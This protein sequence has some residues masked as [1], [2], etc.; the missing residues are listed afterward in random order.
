[1]VTVRAGS[2]VSTMSKCSVSSKLDLASRAICLLIE[3]LDTHLHVAVHASVINSPVGTG[4][5]QPC[6]E[7]ENNTCLD[8]RVTG[9]LCSIV[10]QSN[11]PELW[12][13]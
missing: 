13:T 7:Y 8:A 12:L 11:N 9:A 1:M 6:A 10:K 3:F 4:A 5:K 2:P